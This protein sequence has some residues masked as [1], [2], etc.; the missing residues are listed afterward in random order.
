MKAQHLV[1]GG[2]RLAPCLALIGVLGAVA[3]DAST[4]VWKGGTPAAGPY[5]W[6]NTANWYGGALPGSG[7][8][9]VFDNTGDANKFCEVDT[10][11]PSIRSLTFSGNK[12][13]TVSF[14]AGQSLTVSDA[15]SN[16]NSN[17]LYVRVPLH[18]AAALVVNQ[19]YF[20]LGEN[21]VTSPS[22]FSGGTTVNGPG[23]VCIHG[24]SFGGYN[25]PTNGPL[26]T[27]RL[28]VN[29]GTVQARD[30][31]RTLYNPVKVTGTGYTE[32]GYNLDHIAEVDLDGG[33]RTLSNQGGGVFNLRGRVFN[34]SVIKKGTSSNGLMLRLDS[35]VPAGSN[36]LSLTGD[37]LLQEG[38]L[39]PGNMVNST[40]RLC[41]GDLVM[42]TN[43]IL[44]A[45]GSGHPGYTITNNIRLLGN[46]SLEPYGATCRYQGI[47]SDDGT[48][49]TLRIYADYGCNAYFEGPS[50]NTLQGQ[51]TVDGSHNGAAYSSLILSKSADN[52]QAV[53]G[54]LRLLISHANSSGSRVYYGGFNEQIA[55]TA[56]VTIENKGTFYLC[57]STTPS[58]ANGRRETIRKLVANN[59]AGSVAPSSKA[60]QNSRLWLGSTGSD[61]T[62]GIYVNAS[63]TLSG[64]GKVSAT[65][66]P[67]AVNA[68][69]TL[70]PGTNGAGVLSHEG[71]VVFGTNS[72]YAWDVSNWT[73]TVAGVH[74]DQFAVSGTV[75]IA[76]TPA[77]P[78]T[79]AVTGDGS[80]PKNDRSWV[81]ATATNGISGF[82]AN[83]FAVT[84]ANLTADPSAFALWVVGNDLVLT[85]TFRP[86]GTVILLR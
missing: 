68:G 83:K 41:T 27:G 5:P 52:V 66:M 56:V 21:G 23:A 15:I 43:T 22:T 13:Y 10:G 53:A 75:T 51:I 8:D 25:T 73:G 49:R 33:T 28:T 74:F 2:N 42:N 50:N 30:G 79:I 3:A 64:T 61:T 62:T 70:A 44:G 6:S 32:I 57:D 85:H 78:L 55:D 48:P 17:T 1:R 24:N 26:G 12:G 65:Y 16:N 18:G 19:G 67:L 34:G 58:T 7:D 86:K 9:V 80:T 29:G 35:A 46:A 54:D 76:S 63:G 40:N 36:V 59:P 77:A 47:I 37:F 71:A 72:L 31:T 84:V 45:P 11:A 4:I 38:K 20:V 14:A 81:I 69:G 39:Q 82:A 60:G